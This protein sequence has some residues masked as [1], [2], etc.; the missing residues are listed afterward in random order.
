MPLDRAEAR[1]AVKPQ[2]PALLF[3]KRWL[4]NPK[5]VASITPS[6]PSLSRLIASHVRRDPD[7]VVVEYGGGTGAITQALLESGIPPSRL[8][9]VE[10]DRELAG[11]LR[12]QFP[13]VNVLQGDVRNIR[14]LLPPQFI[15]K[16]GT[17]VVGIPMILIPAEAQRK[18]V[19]EIFAIMPEGR[20]F[21]SYTYS[22]RSP[23][24]R[25]ALGIEG[26]RVG[27]TVANIPPASVWGFTRRG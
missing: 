3:L 10:M 20:R 18:I 26:K 12:T 17:V 19:D 22:A 25:R 21:L 16:V 13:D 2:N 9:T 11:Y 23:L 6:G 8:Y 7:E 24:K 27:F 4:A 15:G 1:T 5:A 14:S